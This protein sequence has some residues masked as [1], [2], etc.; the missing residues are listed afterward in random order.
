[1]ISGDFDL[2]NGKCQSIQF[3]NGSN[4]KREE[5]FMVY[6]SQVT[7]RV[8]GREELDTAV[9]V[10][11]WIPIRMFFDAPNS[12]SVNIYG[13]LFLPANSLT[14]RRARFESDALQSHKKAIV[15]VVA[16]K[17]HTRPVAGAEA[18]FIRPM[19]TLIGKVIDDVSS[20][21]S[22]DQWKTFTVCTSTFIKGERKSM[23]VRFGYFSITLIIR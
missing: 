16:G 1:M 23:H 3:S 4:A 12:M 2:S 10:E 22:V 20:H 11:V 18:N 5:E 14:V 17:K 9:P 21:E 8:Y 6:D 13:R 19:I 7:N 15:E